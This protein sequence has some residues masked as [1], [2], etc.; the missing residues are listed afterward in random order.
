MLDPLNLYTCFLGGTFLILFTVQSLRK[1]TQQQI[2]WPTWLRRK[3]FTFFL[4]HLVYPSILRQSRLW[5]LLQSTYWGGTIVCN[6]IKAHG[7]SA[8]AARAGN[9]AILNFLPLVFAGRLTLLA[10]LLGIRI[11]SF[12]RVHG[13]F[14]IMACMQTALHI[15]LRIRERGWSP[16]HPVEFYGILVRK[17]SPLIVITNTPRLHQLLLL[18]FF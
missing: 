4:H 11:Q 12:I 18:L 16:Q 1:L 8:I 10:D 13:T 5:F 9:L 17:I 3:V 7:T 15:I 14:G 2:I 6:F